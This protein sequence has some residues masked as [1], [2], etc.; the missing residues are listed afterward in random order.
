MNTKH[1]VDGMLIG[2]YVQKTINRLFHE[3]KIHESELILLQKQDYCKIKFDLN[4]PMFKKSNEPRE[5]KGHAR[6]YSDEII[7]GY[8][9]TNDW[10]ERHW[11]AFLKWENTKK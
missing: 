3:N 2:E 4:Y 5:H 10:Y 9:L 7:N 11:D 1:R 6:Y 8:W